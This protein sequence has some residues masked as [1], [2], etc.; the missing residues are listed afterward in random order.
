ML[1]KL[2]E[3]SMLNSKIFSAMVSSFLIL[4]TRGQSPVEYPENQPGCPACPHASMFYKIH[5]ER[6]EYLYLNNGHNNYNS[7]YFT[8]K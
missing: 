8:L 1:T 7:L 6:S 4:H 2:H 5:A 3:S